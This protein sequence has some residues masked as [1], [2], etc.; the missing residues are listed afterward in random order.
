MTIDWDAIIRETLD[1][2]PRGFRERMDTV[3]IF[4]ED[5]PGA[6]VHR[7]KGLARGEM[8]LGF[9]RGV[10]LSERGDDSGIGET[11]PNTI[12]LYAHPIT[13]E[14]ETTD[15]TSGAS[16]TRPSGTS[17]DTT[18][19]STN[20]RSAPS[21]GDGTEGKPIFVHDFPF[22]RRKETGYSVYG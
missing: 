4:V 20:N 21:N 11:L 7:D 15:T 14:A 17:S 19:A 10:P 1:A 3:A 8:L 22:S 9:Y 6:D 12:F 5:E 2:M 18:S 13:K 16:R